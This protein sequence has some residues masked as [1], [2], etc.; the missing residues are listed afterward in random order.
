MISEVLWE[1]Y[2]K[3]L[4]KHIWSKVSD[5]FEAED[6]LQEVYIR[7]VKNEEKLM[8]MEEPRAWL[9]RVASNIIV[10]YYRHKDRYSYVENAD[11]TYGKGSGDSLLD[12][13]NRETASCLL[14]LTELLPEQYKEAILESDLKGIRQNQLGERWNLSYSGAKNRVQRARRKL[15]ETM[16]ECCQVTSDHQ[17]NIIELVSKEGSKEKFSC[18][19]C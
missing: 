17:G 18:M 15:K 12:N 4:K 6:I 5:S 16:L 11:E 2:H 13:Y 1:S 19:D 14:R 3:E 7:A 10:D 9:H 8:H